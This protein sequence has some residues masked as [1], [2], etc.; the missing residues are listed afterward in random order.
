MLTST[1]IITINSN[2]CVINYIIVKRLFVNFSVDTS[3]IID[4]GRSF[5]SLRVLGEKLL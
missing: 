5:H 2:K 4:I 3:S 1:N